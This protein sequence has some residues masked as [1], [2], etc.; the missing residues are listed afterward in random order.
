MEVAV[1]PSHYNLKDIVQAIELDATWY[2]NKP[3][4]CRIA[5]PQ[6]DSEFVDG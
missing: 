3:P 6:S 4:D 1:S 5:A 2:L